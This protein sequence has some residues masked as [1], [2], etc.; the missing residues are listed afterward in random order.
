MCPFCFPICLGMVGRAKHSPRT[1]G[2]P[3]VPPEVCSEAR[4]TI[5]QDLIR[6]PKQPHDC[7][8][9]Q[10]CNLLSRKLP[11]AHVARYNPNKPKQPFNAS[12]DCI[13]PPTQ[14]QVGHEIDGPSAKAPGRRREWLQETIRQLC[15][16]LGALAH[17]T[18]EANLL[19][20][21]PHVGPQYTCSQKSIHP[22]SPK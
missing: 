15:T 12:H 19:A 13:L 8:E 22:P 6:Q 5:M 11:F 4:I 1:H 3:Q 21:L 16:V 2:I 9:E 10:C 14:G 17:L 7:I 20:A 18:S